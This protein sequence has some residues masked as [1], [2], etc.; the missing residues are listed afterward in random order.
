MTLPTPTPSGSSEGSG[1]L[2]IPRRRWLRPARPMRHDQR[3]S[4]RSRT[5]LNSRRSFRPFF[6]WGAAPELTKDGAFY[7]H[8]YGQQPA[9]D[10]ANAAARAI[11]ANGGSADI[12]LR[13]ERPRR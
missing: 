11:V 3:P 2:M 4:I 12:L 1:G 8:Y 7:G 10:A 5:W 6:S 13:G 9:F